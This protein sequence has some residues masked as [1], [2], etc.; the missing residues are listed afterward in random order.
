MILIILLS[1]T[2]CI[3]QNR[4]FDKD[5]F[6]LLGVDSVSIQHLVAARASDIAM[7]KISFEK[8]DPNVLAMTNGGY[9]IVGKKTTEKCID[10]VMARTGCTIGKA[11][12]L[13]KN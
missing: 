8:N 6:D 11:N 10:G 12:L 5:L 7:D 2:A 3:Q 9:A 4:T 1:L 13:M